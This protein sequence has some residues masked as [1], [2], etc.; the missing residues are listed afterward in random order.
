M[1][2]TYGKMLFYN[3][4]GG[5]KI[6]IAKCFAAFSIASMKGNSESQYYLSL[7]YFYHMDDFV[8]KEYLT[9]SKL[10]KYWDIAS[11]MAVRNDRLSF[12]NLFSAAQGGKERVVGAIANRYMKGLGATRDCATAVA[13]MKDAAF[14]VASDEILENPQI[15]QTFYLDKEIFDLHIGSFGGQKYSSKSKE[16]IEMMEIKAERGEVVSSLH[17]GYMNFYGFYSQPVNMTKAFSYFYE[18]K[19][20]GDQTA[21]AFIG[22]MYY[23]GLGVPQN[24]AKAFEIFKTGDSRM[25]Y[26]CSNGLG[27]MY[28][29]GDYVEK[30]LSM[31]YRLFKIAADSG[32]P[33]AQFN[34]AS[35]L[36]LNWT[37]KVHTNSRLGLEYMTLATHQGHIGAM[38]AMAIVHLEGYE[39]YHSC[40]LSEKLL[41]AVLE[42]GEAAS[43]LQKAYLNYQEERFPAAAMMYLEAAYF[44]YEAGLVNAAILLDKNDVF[45]K[46]QSLVEAVESDEIIKSLGAVLGVDAGVLLGHVYEDLFSIGMRLGD[47]RRR[48]EGPSEEEAPLSTKATMRLL[49]S[50]R[51][52][53]NTFATVRLGDYYY[54]GKNGIK[55]NV[56]R[57]FEM[58]L[59][60][61][62]MNKSKDF[63]AQAFLSTGFMRQF[64]V[65]R[66]RD[67]ELARSDYEKAAK[68]GGSLNYISHF[69]KLLIE[70][71][72]LVGFDFEHL[73]TL[74]FA[75]I[76]SRISQHMDPWSNTSTRSYP[77]L[78]L[79]ACL[80]VVL[81]IRVRLKNEL[82]H[83]L[84]SSH[85]IDI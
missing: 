71:E 45:Q 36:M 70:V 16:N 6:Q 85:T 19:L 43:L 1:L 84:H 74:D 41:K 33:S 20:R 5:T 39:L 25:N 31:A 62:S 8:E 55:P 12:L 64:G 52:E 66:K 73:I 80:V 46:E 77:I 29:R 10:D 79:S 68:I 34:L 24:T 9:P 40:V 65:G 13:Y 82:E 28:L 67:L 63:Q 17:L 32:H 38:Y 27:L 14:E 18:A 11:F 3:H 44:G 30:N 61:Q 59:A 22:H 54:Y 53:Y 37:D 21:E 49:E 35:L 50:A 78:L 72:H 56:S 69:A 51:S 23:G 15:L 4:I 47:T 75:S 81:I 2:V 60:A 76:L 7:L 48:R 42:R 58:Y 83:M 26:R 57:A